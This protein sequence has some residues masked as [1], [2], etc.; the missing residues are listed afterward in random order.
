MLLKPD[1]PWSCLVMGAS[2]ATGRVLVSKLANNPRVSRIGAL[3]RKELPAD[4]WGV[5]LPANAAKIVQTVVDYENLDASA[6]AF[7]GYD[8][9]HCC[10]GSTR[11]KA[12]SAAAF[13]QQEFGSISNAGRMAKEGGVRHFNLLSSGGAD[14]KSK[15]VYMRT[16]G[17]L[18]EHAKQLSFPSLSIFR[19]GLLLTERSGESRWGEWFAQKILPVFHPILP[20]KHKAVFTQTVAEA[21]MQ[22]AEHVLAVQ[23]QQQQAAAQPE[24]A[25]P[26]A[27]AAEGAPAAAAP[28]WR[29]FEND[30][31]RLLKVAR[32]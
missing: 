18:E 24:G 11:S 6:D 3:V 5:Q 17:E 29:T 8:V 27:A 20:E 1:A 12:G 19:P 23:Q 22:H 2:G 28:A 32:L 16:K 10:L 31:I 14:H 7:L 26:A 4:Y 9:A 21:M 13:H 25:A 30:D 15:F